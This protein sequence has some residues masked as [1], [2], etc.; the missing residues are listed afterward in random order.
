MKILGLK[1]GR[2]RAVR[3]EKK[4]GQE[5][6][7]G[8][9]T[10]SGRVVT[11][12][13]AVTIAAVFACVRLLAEG[14]SML[15]L[16]LYRRL[17]GG[18]KQEE[19]D[20]PLSKILRRMPNSMQ[21][22]LEFR[23]M[24][25]GHVVLRGNAYSKIEI[26]KRSGQVLS[27]TPLNPARMRPY[28]NDNGVLLYEYRKPDGTALKYTADEILHLRGLSSDGMQGLSVVTLA[29]ECLGVSLA[30]EDHANR[31][32]ANKATPGG[33]LTHPQHFETDE[34]FLRFKKSWHEA[35]SGGNAHGTAILED[36]MKWEQ[37]GLSAE[38]S[39]FLQT[40]KFQ[41][42]EIAT[43]FNVP[44]HM[45]GDLER[46]TFSNIEQMSLN[47]VTYSLMPWLK[48]WEEKLNLSL[49]S[50]DEQ[51]DLFFEFL[52][53]GQLRGDTA[54]RTAY[55]VA[56]L[57]NGWLCPDEVREMENRNPLPGGIGKIFTRP[58]NMGP[59]KPVD[60]TPTPDP[61][62]KPADPAVPA[63]QKGKL[64]EAIESGARLVLRD[65]MGRA[66]RREAKALDRL[67]KK[68][69]I[70]PLT[71]LK[72]VTADIREFLDENLRDLFRGAALQI[73][74]AE[75]GDLP[76]E[77]DLSRQF[78]E[79][80]VSRTLERIKAGRRDFAA[81]ESDRPDIEAQEAIALIREGIKRAA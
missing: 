5:V 23:E 53:D 55:Y 42:T 50:E 74:A 45:I 32:F 68:G 51:D 71:D 33:V 19:R 54:A 12:D 28:L 47:F 40:R 10:A 43:W 14:V 36:G 8:P 57:T 75:G 58:L 17:P 22:S 13:S 77:G 78:S 35:T 70:G 21:T 7:F 81:W 26:D 27:L 49:I 30:T 41:K 63:E 59:A 56:A 73:R 6:F 25:T 79:R 67:S 62:S 9:A 37:I 38:D 24:I 29:R 16:K 60:P 69:E 64:I 65:A 18:G 52:I 72:A 3:A 34:A 1:F 2:D 4:G 46:A 48:R 11:P 61:S 44:P 76:D 31:L 20:H 80:Y 15:P 66:V 39:Q